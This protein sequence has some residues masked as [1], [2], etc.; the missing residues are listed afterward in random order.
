MSSTHAAQALV[1]FDTLAAET[2]AGDVVLGYLHARGLARTATLALVE[3][4]ET[5]FKAT[6]IDP[7]IAGFRDDATNTEFN[8]NRPRGRCSSTCSWRPA[9]NGTPGPR[10]G[11]L[12]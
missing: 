8:T 10:P 12:L 5:R 11:R 3:P 1:D 9:S 2:G 4:D 7:L 6:V